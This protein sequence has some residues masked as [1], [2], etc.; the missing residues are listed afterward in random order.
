METLRSMNA[1]QR[2]SIQMAMEELT[3]HFPG[4]S[5]KEIV[6]GPLANFAYGDLP[7]YS[8]LSTHKVTNVESAT[9]GS[10]VICH[11]TDLLSHEPLIPLIERGEQGPHHEKFFGI[12]GGFTN[13]NFTRAGPFTQASRLGEQPRQGAV[14]ELGEEMIDAEGKPILTI[15]PQRL[16]LLTT[17]IDYSWVPKGQLCTQ[18]SGFEVKLSAEELKKMQDHISKLQND[19]TYRQAVYDRSHGEVRNVCLMKLSDILRMKEDQ[20]FHPQ[21]FEALKQLALRLAQRPCLSFPHF[22]YRGMLP[23]QKLSFA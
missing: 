13:L 23:V 19:P 15:D 1:E 2:Q 20:F 6:A 17:G 12:T 21:E 8:Y 14:R 16:S 10:F 22:K 5:T 11:S 7:S 3:K 9:V 18:Y 4:L